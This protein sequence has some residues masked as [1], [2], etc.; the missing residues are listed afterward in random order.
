MNP[1]AGKETLWRAIPAHFTGLRQEKSDESIQM[2][3]SK[4]LTC[5]SRW[6]EPRTVIL[7][8]D[9]FADKVP[10]PW[11][12]RIFNAMENAPHHR[13]ILRTA[14]AQR[15]SECRVQWPQCLWLGVIVR[16]QDEAYRA[17]LLRQTSADVKVV[18]AEPLLGPLQL[19]LDGIDW[20]IVAGDKGPGAVPL[21]SDWARSL[22]DQAQSAGVAFCFRGWGGRKKGRE[23]DGRVWNEMPERDAR[24]A[25]AQVIPEAEPEDEAPAVYKYTRW[26]AAACIVFAVLY[27]LLRMA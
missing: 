13:Y 11:I 24:K 21:D 12:R 18:A 26:A 25:Q 20:L 10:L 22:R 2:A 19:N 6:Q 15:L 5:P 1:F 17:D 16:K 3:E 7:D 14:N 8:G 9:L 23:L 27:S 4:T